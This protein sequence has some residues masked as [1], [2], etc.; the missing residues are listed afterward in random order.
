MEAAGSFE[1][2]GIRLP[3]YILSRPRRM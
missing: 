3:N 1:I 2:V